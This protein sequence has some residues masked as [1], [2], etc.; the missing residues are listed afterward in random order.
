MAAFLTAAVAAV[1]FPSMAALLMV[2]AEGLDN[3]DGLG[4]KIVVKKESKVGCM[5]SPHSTSN[6]YCFASRSIMSYPGFD[7]TS[8]PVAD[9]AYQFSSIGSSWWLALVKIPRK[10]VMKYGVRGFC[11]SR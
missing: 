2:G 3:E 9:H 1:S 7:S 10:G 5:W 6:K 8:L 11:R 4:S